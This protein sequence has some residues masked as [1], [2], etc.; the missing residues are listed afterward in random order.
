MHRQLISFLFVGIS[1]WL[2]AQNQFIVKLKD[3]SVIS[4]AQLVLPEYR[5]QVISGSKMLYK[6]TTTHSLEEIRQLPDVLRA[7]PDAPLEKRETVPND[8]LYPDQPS[9]EKIALPQAWDYTT[10]GANALG[11][12][13]VIAVIDEGFDISHTDFEGNLWSNPGEIPNDGIDND[14]NGYVDD[15][16]GVN[17][18]SKN[19]QHVAKQ[20]G[21]SVAGIIGARGNNATGIA[22]INWNT[23]LMLIS[24]PNLTI[25]DLFIGY[26]Y[27]LEQRRKYNLTNGQDGAYVVAFNQSLGVT[28]RKPDEFPDWCPYFDEMLD[29]GILFINATTNSE[30][31]VDTQYDMP[32]SCPSEGLITVT[33]T[34]LSDVRV[35]S[36]Y[37]QTTIDLAA[38]GDGSYSLGINNEYRDFTGTSAASPHVSGLVGLLFGY[39]CTDFAQYLKSNPREGAII[40]RDYLLSGV[41]L[42]PSL[43]EETVTGGRLNAINP[44]R[45]IQQEWCKEVLGD[46]LVIRQ[47]TLNQSARTLRIDIV[48][49]DAQPVDYLICNTLGQV[50]YHETVTNPVQNVIFLDHLPGN[51]T[52]GNVYF[53][54]LRQGK[55][56]VA[57]KLIYL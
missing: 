17:L 46:E 39:P 16:Y 21:T 49:K 56:I 27:V 51:I 33:N 42:I 31:D 38:P 36:G 20:H 54:C 18:Q 9:L 45:A 1:S 8:P 32:A 23:Q 48:R 5:W 3:N 11:D 22:G 4:Q 41:D 53:V 50:M 15:Y 26:E 47:V 35:T 10:G 55:S 43:A 7:Y 37:G 14:Q 28:G 12:K 34:N 29:A 6:L 19:D 24:I 52:Y 57:T 2:V 13:I 25:S 44:M 40:V 30:W